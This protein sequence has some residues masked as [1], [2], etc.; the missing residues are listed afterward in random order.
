M[1]FLGDVVS[2]FADTAHWQGTNGI[3]H[4]VEEHVVMSAA[5][6]AAALIVAVPV[7]V[8]LGHAAVSAPWP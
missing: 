8:S 6:I 4:R 1:S 5:V 2:W 3:P 7:G